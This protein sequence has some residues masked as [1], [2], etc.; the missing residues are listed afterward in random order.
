MTGVKASTLLAAASGA[1]V[2]M[3]FIQGLTTKEGL[4]VIASGTVTSV[5]LTPVVQGVFEHYTGAQMTQD[6]T[7]AASFL[8]GLLGMNVLAGFVKLVRDF[9]KDPWGTILRIRG[10]VK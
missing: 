5:Y 10:G 8:T 4:L 7:H 2:S 1:L 3:T 6:W 9:R